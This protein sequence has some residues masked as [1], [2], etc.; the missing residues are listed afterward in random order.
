MSR[1]N[2]IIKV[3]KTEDGARKFSSSIPPK[4]EKKETDIYITGRVGDRLDILADKY[5]GDASKWWIIAQANALGKGSLFVTPGKQIRIPIETD[6][7]EDN[8]LDLNRNR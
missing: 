6:E 1:Y 8:Y 5:Y 2:D 4:I 3:V 7:I